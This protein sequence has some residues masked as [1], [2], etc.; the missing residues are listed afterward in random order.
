VVKA[1]NALE[2][3]FYSLDS[4][5]LAVEGPTAG[6]DEL[7]ETRLGLTALAGSQDGMVALARETGGLVLLNSNDLRP[8]LERV[9]QDGAVYYSLGVTLSK[10][11]SGYQSVRVDVSRKGVTVRARKGYAVR[12]ADERARDVVL[13]ALK[14]NLGYSE[15]PLTLRT[16]PASR[17]GRHFLLPISVTLP[18]SALTFVPEGKVKRATA[19]VS[20]GAM[21]DSGRVSD[22]VR[23]EAAFTIP[24]GVETTTLDF[25]TKLYTRKGNQ[26]IVVNL[27]D[28]LSGKMGTAKAD[29]RIE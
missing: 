27:R 22:V 12:T 18:A 15:I 14:T 8:G 13:A 26:R 10:I 16:E 17:E 7:L 2:I 29:V 21:D 19:D 9:Y 3:T 24:L 6:N 1:A 23:Q 20:I 4:R 28:R 25:T 5:G 11:A